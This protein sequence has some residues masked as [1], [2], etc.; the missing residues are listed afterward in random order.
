MKAIK[1]KIWPEP[2]VAKFHLNSNIDHKSYLKLCRDV[3]K[4]H[5]NKQ[6]IKAVTY[7][8]NSPGG[9]P[10]YSSLMGEKVRLFAKQ[11]KVPYYTFAEDVAASGGY[12]LLCQGEKVYAHPM[13]I[14][15]SIGVVSMAARV[16]GFYDDLKLDPMLITTSD[17]LMEAKINPMQSEKLTEEDKDFIRKI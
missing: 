3:E 11:K 7:V 12:W 6:P 8:I 15:G 9:S 5:K 16:R 10:V 17:Q 13:S 4:A 1:N 2:I 14:I